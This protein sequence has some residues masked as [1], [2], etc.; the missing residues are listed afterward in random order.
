MPMI[1][2]KLGFE[3]M[4]LKVFSGNALELHQAMLG[5]APKSFN[6]VF[7]ITFDVRKLVEP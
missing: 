7:V 1:E 4:D 5:V 6:A 3:Q 2:S